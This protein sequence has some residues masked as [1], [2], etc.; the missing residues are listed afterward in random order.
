MDLPAQTRIVPQAALADVDPRGRQG[1][2]Q[3]EVVGRV[4]EAHVEEGR[5]VACA[6]IAFPD[7][8]GGRG[9]RRR[10]ADDGRR[11]RY[12]GDVLGEAAVAAAVVGAAGW[13]LGGH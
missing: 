12:V 9:R 5:L 4:H 2:E 10:G 13:G 3:Q 7:A 11:E 6:A 8:S 1:G